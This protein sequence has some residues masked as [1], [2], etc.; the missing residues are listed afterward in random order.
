MKLVNLT[1]RLASKE[2]FLDA[3]ALFDVL[4]IA[5]ML[6]LVGS[7]FVLAPG[8]GIDLSV[9]DG[10]ISPSDMSTA[11]SDLSVLNARSNTMFVY[12]GAIYTPESFEK[13]MRKDAKSANRGTLLVKADRSLSAEQLMGICRM[14]KAGGFSKIRLAAKTGAENEKNN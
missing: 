10:E 8:L 2:S 9:L 12:D 14:A 5:L 3:A 13:Q 4:L 7:R 1:S 6:T 11:D